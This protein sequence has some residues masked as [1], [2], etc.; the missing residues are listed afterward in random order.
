MATSV[1]QFYTGI[2]KFHVLLIFGHA[3]QHVNFPDPC[4]G[5]MDS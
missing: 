4:S 3:S 5:S 1:V 2:H